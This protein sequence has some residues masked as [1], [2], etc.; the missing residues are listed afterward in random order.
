MEFLRP[1]SSCM[2]SF[3]YIIK[4][5][6]QIKN[7]SIAQ[8]FSHSQRCRFAVRCYGKKT[9]HTNFSDREGFNKCL[10][11]GYHVMS[12]PS[13]NQPWGA[14]LSGKLYWCV[15]LFEYSDTHYLIKP[16]LDRLRVWRLSFPEGMVEGR[17]WRF[18]LKPLQCFR[19]GWTDPEPT[20]CESRPLAS[21]HTVK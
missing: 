14:L 1:L 12:V 9:M 20:P 19:C 13:K 15:A 5:T 2:V 21:S 17:I 11:L 16:V 18:E 6:H 3:T 7:L 4:C 10:T 8:I